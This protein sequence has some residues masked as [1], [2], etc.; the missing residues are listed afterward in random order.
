DIVFRSVDGILIGTHK[1]MLG[2]LSEGFPGADLVFTTDEAVSLT[3]YSLVLRS[4]FERMHLRKHARLSGKIYSEVFELAE[5][6][7]K[8]LVYSVMASCAEYI[9]RIASKG[10]HSMAAFRHGV[11]YDYTEVIDQAA[12]YI[13]DTH[14]NE[15]ASRFRNYPAIVVAWV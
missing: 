13:I 14:P 4:L 2:H 6:A 9:E 12:P 15:I 3:E 7:E 8:Y 1:T 10:M 5:A 11:K